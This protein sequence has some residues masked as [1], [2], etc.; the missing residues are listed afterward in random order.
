VELIQAVVLGVVQGIAEFLPISSSGHLVIVPE[1][2]GWQEF[3]GNVSFDVLL[4]LGTLVAVF[5][6]FWSDLWR[7]LMA[8]FSSD[9]DKAADKRLAWLVVAGTFITGVIGLAFDDFF[10]SLFDRVIWVGLFLMVTS[11]ILVVAERLST[12]RFDAPERMTWL[13]AS[14]IGLAQGF[15]IM[16]GI[17]RSGS[18]ISAGLLTGLDREQAARFSFLLSAPII[19]LASG[20]TAYDAISSGASSLPSLPVSIAAFAASAIAG[21]VSIAWLLNYLKKR[22]LYPFAVYT[23]LVGAAV[24]AWQLWLV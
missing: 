3:A 17:S 2:F 10:K 12:K 6:Y 7:L 16:P 1:L 11:V 4:H 14:L 23:A 9:P 19:L 13:Q 15:A 5:A 20:K 18:T 24:V 21:Y 8:A 22:S